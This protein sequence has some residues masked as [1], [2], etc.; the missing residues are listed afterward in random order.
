[1]DHR[2]RLLLDVD[3][4]AFWTPVGSCLA[5]HRRALHDILLRGTDGVPIRWGTTVEEIVQDSSSVRVRF[6]DGSTG[7]YD[8]VVGADGI[9]S[10]VRRIV[11]PGT[12]PRHVGQVSWRMVI[13]DE[14]PFASWTVMLRPDRA[15]LTIPLGPRRFYC[16]ADVTT[17][18]GSDP[19]AGSLERF[20]ALYAD[21]AAPVP[22]IVGKLSPL[23]PPYFSSIE[24]V[25]LPRW[26]NG[27]VVLIG[28]AAHATSPNMAQG[29]SMAIE[30][31]LVL[32]EALATHAT[33]PSALTTFEARRAPRVRWVQDQ[34]HRRDRA[35]GLP[36]FVRNW[37]VR[38]AGRRMFETSNRPLLNVP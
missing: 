22:E 31:A 24:E 7:A 5:I 23:T 2:G 29:A 37:V 13:E 17:P 12:V 19:T 9:Y 32:A 11:F 6:S 18:V 1:M 25:A 28:D 26:V 3:L 8:V 16:Y 34:T 35:R 20:R 38:L 30:D 4:D 33:A 15:F 21:F 27:R 10:S 36:P 14:P